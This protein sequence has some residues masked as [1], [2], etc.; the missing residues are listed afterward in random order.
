VAAA[1]EVIEMEAAPG[2]GTFQKSGA[3]YDAFMGR[4]S[5]PLATLFADAA[6]VAAG[7]SALDVGC[8]PGALTAVLVERLGTDA[9]AAFDPSEPFVATCGARHPGVDVR[10][11]RAEAIPFDDDRFDVAL[12]QL[13]LHFVSDPAAAAGEL[14]R[15]VRGG[16]VVAACVWDFAEEMEML[17]CFWDAANAT[18]PAAPDEA[19]TLRFGRPGELADWLEDAGYADVT[20]TTLA[21]A[22]EYEDFDELW[23]GFLAGIGPAGAYC[24]SL[25]EARRSALR[26]ELFR[27]VGEP[28][29]AFTLGAMARTAR[30]RVPA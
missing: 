16:G 12:A 20:E 14:R 3:A 28:A 26:D 18:D 25:P 9:V 6:G 13:V 27:R 8:G 17:R 10:H 30:G 7:Q 29:G 22:S 1:T 24:V 4:Y 5:R 15:V 23:S 2:A 11:G 21:V 19:R